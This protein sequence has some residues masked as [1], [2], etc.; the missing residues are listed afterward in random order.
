MNRANHEFTEYDEAP[1]EVRSPP[2]APVQYDVPA[3][4]Q[5]E[6]PVAGAYGNVPEAKVAPAC[7]QISS[8]GRLD[9]AATTWMV[10]ECSS[11]RATTGGGSPHRSRRRRSHWRRSQQGSV[12]QV[13]AAQTQQPH[14]GGPTSQPR[15]HPACVCE[16]VC[17]MK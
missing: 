12:Q 15:T 16:I 10:R 14:Q 9:A 7:A 6:Q 2:A 13:G 8:M 4:G 1:E 11:V 3:H 5:L 17:I